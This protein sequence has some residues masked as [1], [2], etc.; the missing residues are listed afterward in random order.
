MVITEAVLSNIHLYYSYPPFLPITIMQAYPNINK[1]IM[2][3]T[4]VTEVNETH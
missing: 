2:H 4:L 1:V 3:I